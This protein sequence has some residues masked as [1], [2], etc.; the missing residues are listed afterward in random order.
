MTL[1]LKLTASCLTVETKKKI[2]SQRFSRSGVD[3][4][5]GWSC[6]VEISHQD[7]ERGQ[8]L[9]S[10]RPDRVTW[11]RSWNQHWKLS[12]YIYTCTSISSCSREKKLCV[13]SSEWNDNPLFVAPLLFTILVQL[14]LNNNWLLFWCGTFAFCNYL[15]LV[16]YPII[17]HSD[18]SLYQTCTQL[19][20]AKFAH[21]HISSQNTLT[22]G[23]Y[24]ESA[25]GKKA[26][27]KPLKKSA[28]PGQRIATVSRTV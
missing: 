8:A 9:F 6:D 12:S 10:G 26:R 3:H 16:L 25:M 14:L 7:T 4:R 22:R 2:L 27:E 5:Y 20:R 28:N 19:Y 24:S 1:V 15:P 18:M 21:G 11:K 17:L 23:S 13:F